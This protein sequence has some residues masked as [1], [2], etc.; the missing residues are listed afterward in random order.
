MTKEE[1]NIKLVELKSKFNKDNNAL[2]KEYAFANNPHKVG[3]VIKDHIGS[4]RIETIGVYIVHGTP[5][6]TYSGPELT[7]KLEPS[8]KGTKRTIYQSNLDSS[9]EN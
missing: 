4:I 7:K 5:E 2:H 1:Y 6:C 9:N 8:K 3:D